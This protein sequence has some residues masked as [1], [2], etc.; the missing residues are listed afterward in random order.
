MSYQFAWRRGNCRFQVCSSSAEAV[1]RLVRAHV[2]MTH[3]GRIDPAD[4]ER[5]MERVELA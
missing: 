1:K 3:G 4:L 5:W 2:R